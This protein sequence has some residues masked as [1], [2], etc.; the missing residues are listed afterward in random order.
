MFRLPLLYSIGTLPFLSDFW[1]LQAEIFLLQPVG[2]QL[3]RT[4]RN[5]LQ[6]VVAEAEAVVFRRYDAL[7]H[8]GHL[9]L[10]DA[11][12]LSAIGAAGLD[13]LAKQH[14]T[15]SLQGVQPHLAILCGGPQLGDG[16]LEAVDDLNRHGVLQ[17]LLDAAAQIPGAVGRRIGGFH[18]VLH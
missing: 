3:S 10:I 16:V 9:R 15:A 7:F 18:Q 2:G 1:V 4:G 12:P 13:I 5:P 14:E 8:A 6:R 17:L 11:D